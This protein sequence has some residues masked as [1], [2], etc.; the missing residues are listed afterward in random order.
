MSVSIKSPAL[1]LGNNLFPR[2]LLAAVINH[3]HIYGG[4]EEELSHLTIKLDRLDKLRQNVVSILS[5]NPIIKGDILL[6][7][8]KDFGF[9]QEIGDICRESVYVH[10]SFCSP[11]ANKENIQSK[12]L[13]YW[14][15]CNVAGLDE[16]IKKGWQCAS[17]DADAKRLMDLLYA[18]SSDGETL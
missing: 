16:K 18:T 12:W 1:S 2:V 17:S 7:Q 13:G 14:N 11:S 9:A 3:P 4:V 10:A 15:D 8:L 6:K 5:N